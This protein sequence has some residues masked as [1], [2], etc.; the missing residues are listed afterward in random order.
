MGNDADVALVVLVSMT[1]DGVRSPASVVESEGGVDDWPDSSR[2]SMTPYRNLIGSY[3]I[4]ACLIVI[5]LPTQDVVKVS[6]PRCSVVIHH[7]FARSPPKKMTRAK[8]RFPSNRRKL[9]QNS[10]LGL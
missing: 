10:K 1:D 3:T 4:M 6:V 8:P 5:V 9:A 2:R 7:L